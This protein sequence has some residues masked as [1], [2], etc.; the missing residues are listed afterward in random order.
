MMNI[1]NLIFLSIIAIIGIYI[2]SIVYNLFELKDFYNCLSDQQSAKLLSI[3]IMIGTTLVISSLFIFLC[4]MVCSC[5]A[6]IFGSISLGVYVTII[7]FLG[8]LMLIIGSL[9][10]NRILN[11]VDEKGKSV[12][13]ICSKFKTDTATIWAMGLF[14]IIANGIFIGLK[15]YNVI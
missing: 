2:I 14:I 8:L 10:S 11:I 1:T 4:S 15:F 13:P 7:T 6:N 9:L 5:P 12:D 3:L